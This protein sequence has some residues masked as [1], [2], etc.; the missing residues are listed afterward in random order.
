MGGDR[1]RRRIVLWA[2]AALFACCGMLAGARGAPASL[3]LDPGTREAALAEHVRYYHDRTGNDGFDEAADALTAGRFAPLP[4]GSSAFGFRPEGAFWFHARVL[5]RDA[6][7]PRWLMV[8]QY[9]LSDSIEVFTRYPDGR[10]L[11][12]RGGDHHPFAS[13]SIRYR[14]PNFWLDLPAGVPVD[15]FVRVRS[16]SSMQVPLVLYTPTAFTELARD[17]QLAMG[18]YYG[19]LLALFVYNLVLWLTL[20]DASY[21]WY[22]LHIGAFGLVLFTLNGMA[23][24]Y[25]W[26]DSAWMADHAVPLSICLA[27]LCM[28][29]FTRTF[30]SL[31]RRWSWGDRAALALM[32]YFTL[33]GVFA[34]Y[35]PYH[36]ATP[37]ASA[38]VFVTIG[39]I[40]AASL[41][42]LRR[43]YQPARLFLLA[44]AM[45]LCG[46]AMFSAIA[47]G[48]LPKNFITEYGVQFGSA[49]EMLLLSVALGYRYA[50]LRNENERI[51]REAKHQL[52]QQVQLRTSELRSA[53][54]QLEDAH[55]RLR[56][57]SRRDTLTGL[58]NRS[59][60][61]E[62]FELLLI[63]AREGGTPLALLMIDLDHFKQ[64]NDRHGHL[65]GDHCLRWA[66]Q[67]IGQTLRP[68]RALPA[69]F[70]GEEFVVALP[71]RTLEQ[72]AHIAELVAHRLREGPCP[73]GPH[74]IRMSASIGVHQ[75]D[76][77]A[78]DG[79]DAALHCAD[80]A[81]YRAKHDGRDCIRVWR[82]ESVAG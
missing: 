14:H 56:E 47:F 64:I 43:G 36:V 46:T 82:G 54:E 62:A 59:H 1:T 63:E 11:K 30:L 76:P 23:F 73:H 29:Q 41:V 10:V 74:R 68:Y 52:E 13:R 79:I 25:L 51:V 28:V 27:M 12:Q 19:I 15:V 45:F 48:L 34:T 80:E 2:V 35:L 49:L 3:R 53:L 40:V 67:I 32:A 26:P 8:Q 58:F 71:E 33:L 60:F 7:E 70:G 77:Q 65:V 31:S 20:R 66:A 50:A 39:W 17:A 24:E 75:V 37:I 55:G 38:S 57:S 18:L 61:R 4:D 42:A 9:A 21:F 44:W 22:L 69:R 81:L 16:Q 5:N 6:A 78:A 72:A